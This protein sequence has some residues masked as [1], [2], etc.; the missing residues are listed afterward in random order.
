[1]RR[2]LNVILP[3]CLSPLTAFIASFPFS[4]LQMLMSSVP[5]SSLIQLFGCLFPN[6]D[7]A[8]TSAE[9]EYHYV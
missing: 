9:V 2:M 7:Y 5:E 3:K 8:P 6:D 4:I 1:M